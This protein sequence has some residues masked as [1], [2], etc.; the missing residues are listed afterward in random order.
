LAYLKERKALMCLNDLDSKGKKF[1]KKVF[2]T[3]GV[4]FRS[5]SFN[6]IPCIPK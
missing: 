4:D 2:G 3:D 6:F 5:L 1:N